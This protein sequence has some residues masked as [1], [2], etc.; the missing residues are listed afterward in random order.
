MR[1]SFAGY[2]AANTSA[3]IAAADELPLSLADD[4]ATHSPISHR[5]ELRLST[6]LLVRTISRTPD[7]SSRR[8]KLPRRSEHLGRAAARRRSSST[9]SP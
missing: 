7:A 8:F 5:P 1:L 4:L 3:A 9:V 2:I 6:V